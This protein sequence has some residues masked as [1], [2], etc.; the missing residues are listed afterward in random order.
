[1]AVAKPGIS[2][3]PRKI[4]KQ[5]MTVELFVWNVLAGIVTYIVIIAAQAAWKRLRR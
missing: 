3:V 4:T 2:S 5:V 1:V